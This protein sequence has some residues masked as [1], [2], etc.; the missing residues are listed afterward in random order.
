[1]QEKEKVPDTWNNQMK[2]N[3]TQCDCGRVEGTIIKR[4][5]SWW[6]NSQKDTSYTKHV[7]CLAQGVIEE[8]EMIPVGWNSQKEA[9]NNKQ[10][11]GPVE[12]ML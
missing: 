9:S 8:T 12:D 10:T 3:N 11:N 7:P 2:A 1:M 6:I 5:D 4:D